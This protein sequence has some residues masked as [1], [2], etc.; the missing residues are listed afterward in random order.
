MFD[1]EFYPTPK[2]IIELMV[3]RIG[4]VEGKVILGPIVTG[5]HFVTGKHDAL[6]CPKPT[7]PKRETLRSSDEG[8]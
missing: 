1:K 3:N 7:R 4:G 5:K 8:S 6:L 2:N